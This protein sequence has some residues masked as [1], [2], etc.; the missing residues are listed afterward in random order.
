MTRQPHDF[1]PDMTVA[2]VF[3]GVNRYAAD[4][5]EVLEPNLEAAGLPLRIPDTVLELGRQCKEGPDAGKLSTVTVSAEVPELGEKVQLLGWT[6]LVRATRG[7]PVYFPSGVEAFD[8]D[9][10]EHALSRQGDIIV[11]SIGRIGVG[12]KGAHRKAAEK[13]GLEASIRLGDL[14]SPKRQTLERILSV[15]TGRF[16]DIELLAALR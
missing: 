6:R 12:A 2:Q 8:E 11:A 9:A 4:L 14:S 1:G 15:T 10:T 7:Q 13:V 16:S 3:D 5:V